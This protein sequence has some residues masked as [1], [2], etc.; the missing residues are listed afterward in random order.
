MQMPALDDA[1]MQATGYIRHRWWNSPQG[2][3]PVHRPAGP[4]DEG[5]RERINDGPANAGV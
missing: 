3:V 2:I 4:E 5:C 1:T